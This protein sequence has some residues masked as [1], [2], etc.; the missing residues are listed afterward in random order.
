MSPTGELITGHEGSKFLALRPDSDVR[1]AL[2][3]NLGPGETLQAS[4]LPR[5]PTPAGGGKVWSWMDSGNNEQSAKS[6]EGVL[7][8]YG[9]RGTLWGSEEPQSKVSPVLVTYDLFTAFRVNDE[10]GDLDEEVLESC[11]TGDR[12]YDWTRLPYNQY[13]SA[14]NG[15]GKR[16]KE[17]RLL[18]I[19]REDEAW[20]LLV[21]AGVGSLKTVVPFVKRL[22]VPHFRACVSLTLEKVENAGGQPYSQIVPKLTGTLSKEEGEL[23]RRLYTVPLSRV[24]QQIDSVNEGE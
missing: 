13:G 9:V 6:I 21:S 16:C 19:L 7:A 3:A 4:D 8:Y 1:E 20:P 14:A 12:T 15:R 23:V 10:I 24:A 17:S 22:P 2:L 11:R 5:V 18:A